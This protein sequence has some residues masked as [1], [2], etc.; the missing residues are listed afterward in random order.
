[1]LY[2]FRLMCF[3]TE[4]ALEIPSVDQESESKSIGN[5][6]QIE[7]ESD[8]DVTAEYDDE[9]ITVG[10]CKFALK[11]FYAFIRHTICSLSKICDDYMLAYLF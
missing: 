1:M 3:N 6:E 2:R 10:R 4:P 11:E 9:D 8:E 5:A 7:S